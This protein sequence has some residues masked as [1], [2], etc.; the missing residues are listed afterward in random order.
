MSRIR[1]G[2]RRGHDRVRLHVSAHRRRQCSGAAP[3]TQKVRHHRQPKGTS[4]APTRSSASSP[5]AASSTPSARSRASK[6]GKKVTKQN[7]RMP[8]SAHQRAGAPA[9]PPGPADPGA[10]P[11]SIACSILASLGPINLNLLGLFVRTNQI[12]LRIDAVRAPGNLLGNLLCGIT[13]ILD[14]RTLA[15]TPLGQLTADPQRASRALVREPNQI[16]GYGE[17]QCV[18]PSPLSSPCSLLACL[19]SRRARS[20]CEGTELVYRAAPCQ[21]RPRHRRCP[22]A[23]R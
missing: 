15:N 14:P 3:L 17:A 5:R 1:S 6:G 4:R 10:L 11:A 2:R 23:E 18:S 13:G 12:N 20:R 8:A 19:R 9:W 16:T 22:N 21:Y 7:V